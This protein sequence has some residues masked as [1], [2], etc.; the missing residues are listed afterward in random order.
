M[1]FNK[2]EGT[3]KLDLETMEYID[4]SVISCFG[5]PKGNPPADPVPIIA[6]TPPVEEASVQM[7]DEDSTDK[8]KTSKKSLK[9]PLQTSQNAGLSNTSNV[10][11]RTTLA[12][13]KV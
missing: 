12:G 4:T 1:L 13:L 8:T 9:V 10:G 5:G 3:Q 11:G 2:F 7:E 6:P